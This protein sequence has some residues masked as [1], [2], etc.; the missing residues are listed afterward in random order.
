MAS[1]GPAVP[2]SY[3]QPN[4]LPGSDASDEYAEGPAC[5]TFPADHVRPSSFDTRTVS[6]SRLSVVAGFEKYSNFPAAMKLA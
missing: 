6:R 4:C 5:K 2:L 1:Y 3:K